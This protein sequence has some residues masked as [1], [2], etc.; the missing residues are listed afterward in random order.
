MLK[1]N[2]GA[3][4]MC[5]YSTTKLVEAWGGKIDSSSLVWTASANLASSNAEEQQPKA[6]MH[7]EIVVSF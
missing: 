5:D 7:E 4:A 3:R 1:I 6:G 2:V